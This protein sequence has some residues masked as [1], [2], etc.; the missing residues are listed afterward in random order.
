MVQ[1]LEDLAHRVHSRLG[2][3]MHRLAV[4][5][6][7]LRVKVDFLGQISGSWRVV[8]TNPTSHTCVVQVIVQI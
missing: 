8:V 3:R 1:V 4:A 7:E 6:W 2:L 5:S